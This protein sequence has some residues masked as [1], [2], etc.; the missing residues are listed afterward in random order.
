MPAATLLCCLMSASC[1][2]C[3]VQAVELEKVLPQQT[4]ERTIEHSD[5]QQRSCSVYKEEFTPFT[6][7]AFSPKVSNAA[8]PCSTR[9][10]GSGIAVAA[11]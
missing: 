6:A 10:D 7:D 9:G 1:L 2:P 8:S 4:F 11:A 5:A 3:A